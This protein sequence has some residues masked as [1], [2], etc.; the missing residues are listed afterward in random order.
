MRVNADR[1]ERYGMLDVIANY[2]GEWND[3]SYEGWAVATMPK[4]ALLGNG[5]IGITSG[6]DSVSK[7]GDR[8]HQV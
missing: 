3:S 7:E 4:T 2:Y 8:G 6:G 5:D 1:E